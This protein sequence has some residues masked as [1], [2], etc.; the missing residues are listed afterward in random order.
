MPGFFVSRACLRAT[1]VL[2]RLFTYNMGFRRAD[3][4]GGDTYHILEFPSS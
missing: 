3:T 4:V 1:R 2:A